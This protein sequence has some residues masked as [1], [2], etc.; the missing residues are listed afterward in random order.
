MAPDGRL[1]DQQ[2]GTGYR[3]ADRQVAA[4]P[5]EGERGAHP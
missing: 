3:L 4:G 1:R 2:D 5:L